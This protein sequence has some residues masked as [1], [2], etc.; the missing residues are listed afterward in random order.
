[1]E[2]DLSTNKLFN[3]DTITFNKRLNFIYGKNGTGKSTI[4]KLML[5]E[6][7]TDD[8]SVFAFQGFDSVIGENALLNAIVLGETNKSIEAQI[9]EKENERQRL[10][11]EE[12]EKNKIIN[13][14]IEGSKG[15]KK[16]ILK[17]S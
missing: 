12:E 11:E 2:L 14:G 4:T 10:K 3:A 1:M 15:Q 17:K 6:C 9:T 5:K 13:P 7:G 8:I 16:R